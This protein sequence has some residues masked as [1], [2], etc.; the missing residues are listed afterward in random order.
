MRFKLKRCVVA[1]V[2]I[3]CIPFVMHM[4]DILKFKARKPRRPKVELHLAPP[5]NTGTCDKSKCNPTKDG[6]L[7]VHIVAH[8]HDDVGW[9]KTMDQYY[10]GQGGG[11]AESFYHGGECTRCILD[12]AIRELIGNPSRRFIF[13]E[14]AF[15]SAWFN[16]QTEDMKRQV[17]A[18]INE[19]RLE[20]IIGGWSMSDSATTYY[21]D[22]IDQHTHGFQ[23]IEKEFGEC[24]MPKSGWHVDQFGHS[25]EHSSIFAQFGFDGLFLGRIDFQDQDR[26]TKTANMET[27]WRTSPDSLGDKTSLFTSVLY[28][29]YF[30]PER[31]RWEGWGPG[32]LS[33]RNSEN[34]V[35]AFIDI[36][37]ERARAYKTKHV[38]IPFGGD[39]AFNTA[40]G[41]FDGIDNLIKYVNAKQDTGSK[42]NVLY[43]TP[44]CYINSVNKEAATFETMSTDFFPYSTIPNTFWTGFFTS[45]PGLKRHVKTASSL[46]QTCKQMA[47]LAQLQHTKANVDKLKSAVGVLQHHDA[48]T[49]TEMQHVTDDYNKMLSDG[50]VACQSVIDDAYRALSTPPGVA[51]KQEFCHLLNIS[52]CP[53]TETAKTFSVNL[54]NPLGWPVTHFVRLPIPGGTYT[55]VGDGKEIRAET[56][57][58]PPSTSGIPERGQST[59]KAELVFGADVPPLGFASYKVKKESSSDDIPLLQDNTRDDIVIENEFLSLTV[60]AESGLT[61]TLTNLVTKTKI[62]FEQSYRYYLSSEGQQRDPNDRTGGFLGS[63][64]RASGA[65]AFV[66]KEGQGPVRLNGRDSKGVN[67]K[68]FKGLNALEIHQEF[69]SW[70]TQVIRLYDGAPYLEMEWT[71]GPIPDDDRQSKELISNFVTDLQTEG[72]VYTDS[73]GREMIQRRLDKRETWNLTVTSPISGNYYPVTGRIALQDQGTK[74]QLTVLTDRCQ[75]G[76]SIKDGEMELLVHRR[77]FKD[78]D[79]G[80]QEPLNE[81]GVDGRGLIARGKHYV[82]LNTIER[83]GQDFRPLGLQFHHPPTT[84]F[85]A[86]QQGLTDSLHT[87]WFGLSAPLPSN[88]HLLTLDQVPGK[89]NKLLLRLEHIFEKRE[90]AESD[91][92]VELDLEDLFSKLK[93]TGV[94]ELTLGAN[95]DVSSVSRLRWKTADG[96]LT[97]SQ[98]GS[99][100]GQYKHE[101]P[102]TITLQPME[103][104][105]FHIDVIQKNSQTG[106]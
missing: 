86:S 20:L 12:N 57:P 84:S 77:T 39:F 55:V 95:H 19:R 89:V 28:D 74:A 43:S 24:A 37:V 58:L 97:P 44:T 3:A 52:S 92:I 82:F 81:K 105:T 40:A 90:L 70:V 47:A 32:M 80:V 41:W 65:Y 35:N 64:K 48:I 15:L 26:R 103:I 8:S 9:K 79:L 38:L 14:M 16:E 6:M 106:T 10:S 46:L 11:N 68:T 104:R 13:V 98:V 62:E 88:V 87:Q 102:Y 61:K 83:A 7:N 56:V 69:S 67:V 36:A 78:D 34:Y 17:K 27:I 4:M 73:N 30:S 23:W 85:S 76:A 96:S 31:F 51:P 25:R 42:V 5:T 75:G 21:D 49:G 45:R 101:A 100:E 60:D 54:F 59:A 53:I 29:G 93:I 91:Q 71:I 22:V 72:I 18:L 99:S 63:H 94:R 2:F 66:P 50:E 33:A 1:L